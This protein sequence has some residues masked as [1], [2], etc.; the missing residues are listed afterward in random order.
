LIYPIKSL[1]PVSVKTTE[2][3]SEGLKYDRRFMLLK[4]EDS[5]QYKNIQV[6]HFPECTRFYQEIETDSIVVTYR[7]PEKPLISPTEEQRSALRVPLDPDITGLDTVEVKLFGSAA[8]AYRMGGSYDEWFTSCLGYKA[9]L[10]YIGDSRRSVLAHSPNNMP[11][12]SQQK[13]GWL[14]SIMPYITG[15][16]PQQPDK[17][18]LTFNE[19]APFLLTSAA[20]LRDVNARLPEGQTVDMVRFR[21]NIVVDDDEN[22]SG[23][24]A[25]DTQEGSTSAINSGSSAGSTLGAWEEDYWAELR[26]ADTCRLALT[27]N[28]ARC[29]SVNIDYD[30][31]RPAEGESGAILKKLMKDRRVDR[32]NKWSPIFGRYAFLLGAGDQAD[33]VTSIAVGDEVQVVKRLLDRDSWKWP[34]TSA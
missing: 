33:R 8:T 12:Q 20:S 31:G 10:V 21:P 16:S 5:G 27:A 3:R 9:M 2:L 28:C 24:V 30:T 1:R 15:S 26:I 19:A 34:K 23:G 29:I 22:H 11:R 17:D 18:W 4:L 6:L 13:Q 7:I 25:T 14:S 32:G